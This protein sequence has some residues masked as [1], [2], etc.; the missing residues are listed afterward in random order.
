MRT[1]HELKIGKA[2]V[3]VCADAGG[4]RA[5]DEENFQGSGTWTFPRAKTLRI[6]KGWTLS[7]PRA[8]F[9]RDPFHTKL[10]TSEQWTPAEYET[11]PDNLTTT[12]AD[13]AIATLAVLGLAKRTIEARYESE[14]SA[15]WIFH[16]AQHATA[17]A[18]ADEITKTV[19]IEIA[20]YRE[21]RANYN[22]ALAAA[23]SGVPVAEIVREL[24]DNESAYLDRF[25]HGS[26]AL[27]S[28]L[29]H[30]TLRAD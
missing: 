2:T 29:R 6:L 25:Q 16:D 21:E 18:D 26:N 4:D 27:D 11:D 19:S 10:A 12:D 1:T 17:D 20:D 3:R 9:T 15:F 30:L 28:F 22:G 23:R 13:L 5:G 24:V 7:L 8:D 14:G